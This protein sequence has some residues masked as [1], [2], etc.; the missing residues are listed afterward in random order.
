MNITKISL[1]RIA[2]GDSLLVVAGHMGL[3]ARV[4][5]HKKNP[6]GTLYVSGRTNS[7]VYFG[8]EWFDP[9]TANVLN[10]WPVEQSNLTNAAPA[11]LAACEA[12]LA[13]SPPLP[14]LSPSALKVVRQLANA[15]ALATGQPTQEPVECGALA[16]STRRKGVK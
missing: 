15:I 14:E 10:W 7:N 13:L 4:I 8:D 12:A 9:T 16:C 3:T 11:L 6:D 2:V 5:V 1:Q